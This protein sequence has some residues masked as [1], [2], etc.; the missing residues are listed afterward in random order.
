MSS[1][2]CFDKFYRH[3]EVVI[4]PLPSQVA[5]GLRVR[6]LLDKQHLACTV[7][8]VKRGSQADIAGVK[9]GWVLLCPKVPRMTHPTHYAPLVVQTG[10]DPQEP[11]GE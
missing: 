9:P 11:R 3:E 6:H 4:Y 1:S 2:S 7:V 8:K 5:V 10:P